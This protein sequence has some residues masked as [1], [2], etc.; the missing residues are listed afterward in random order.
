VVRGRLAGFKV[1]KRV[2]F[3]PEIPRTPAGKAQ[4]EWAKRT[5]A[6]ARP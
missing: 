3:V 4:Y 1:P 5:A 2:V 6:A